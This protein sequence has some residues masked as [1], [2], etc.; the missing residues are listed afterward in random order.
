MNKLLL[1]LFVLL[2]NSAIVLAQTEADTTW[3]RT[4][5]AGI[6]L[7]QAAFSDNWRAGGISSI[8]LNSHLDA[9]ADYSRGR[10]TWDNEAQLQ[11]GLIKNKGDEMRK[12][13]DRIYLDTKYG[14]KF[15]SDW[16]A[17]FS[18]NFL[19][20]FAPGYDDETDADG[21]KVLVSNFLSPGYLTF[22]LGAEYKPNPSF[23]LRLS[24]FA[25]RFTFLVDD[26]V[27]A[28]DRYGVPEGRKV[29]TEWLAAMVQATFKRDIATNINLRLNYMGYLNYGEFTFK[30]V[31][32]RLNAVLN[33]KVN[34]Y[35]NVNLT[36]NL[37][38]D[39]DQDADIQY[40]QSLGLGILYTLQGFSLNR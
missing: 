22:A 26:E 8:A 11:Y 19:S 28:D 31:D 7:N 2:L 34:R 38:Y 36:G 27:A 9:R 12:S 6:N 4:F 10:V 13:V 25:P 29:R 16:N 23:S 20:Q 1:T 32:H 14:Y 30:R 35:I 33:A 39:Y 37:I 24:P 18:A 17:F 5:S 3:R 40:S 21:N 15:T